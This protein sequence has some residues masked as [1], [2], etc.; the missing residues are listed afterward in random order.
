MGIRYR[1]WFIRGELGMHL[2]CNSPIRRLLS[3]QPFSKNRRTERP[4]EVVLPLTVYGCFPLHRNYTRQKRA[5]TVNRETGEL[6]NRTV[7][8]IE[9]E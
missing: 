8:A 2:Q 7:R 9:G 3:N 5:K 4:Q 6:V 1:I